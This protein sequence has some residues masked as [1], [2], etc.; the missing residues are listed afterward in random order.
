MKVI[1]GPFALWGIQAQV[2][3]DVGA[4]IETALTHYAR[5][6]RSGRPPSEV[7]AFRRDGDAPEPEQGGRVFNLAVDEGTDRVLRYEAERQGTSLDRLVDHTIMV[8][9]ADMERARPASI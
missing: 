9:L 5:R 3:S 6:L 2:G 4:A 8:F 7:P 1:V